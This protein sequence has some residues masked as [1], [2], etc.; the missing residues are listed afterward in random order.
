M[1]MQAERPEG[2]CA[3]RELRT[4]MSEQKNM[5]RDQIFEFDPENVSL[6]PGSAYETAQQ[7]ARHY[8]LELDPDRLLYPYRREAGVSQPLRNGSPVRGYPS[9]ESTGLDGHIGG[10]YLSG[11]AGFWAATHD[12]VFLDRTLIMLHGLAR[13]QKAHGTGFVGGMPHSARLFS[14]LRAGDIHAQSFDLDGSW[15]P[16]YNLHKVFAGLIETWVDYECEANQN[17]RAH[18]ASDLASHIVMR[19][20]EWWCDLSDHL[21]DAQF[22]QMLACEYGGL[23]ESFARLYEL[24]GNA[25]YLKQA[26]R[27]ELDP[28]FISL[29]RGKDCLTG[30][31]ANTQ[32]PKILGYARIAAITGE[33]PAIRAVSTFWNSVVHHRSVSIGAHSVAEHFNSPTDFSSMIL[34]R[35]GVETCNS[36][37]M[38]KLAEMLYMHT[39]AA[40]CLNFWERVTLNHL[41][42]SVSSEED[43]FVYFTPMRPRH[44]R[45]YSSAQ[46][47]FWCCVGTGL[48]SHSRYGRL[49]YTHQHEQLDVNIFTPS[50]LDWQQKMLTVTQNYR[51]LTSTENVGQLTLTATNGVKHTLVLAIRHPDWVLHADYAFHGCTAH[52]LTASKATP[53]QAKMVQ[54]EE[55]SYPVHF[56]RFALTWT[57]TCTISFHHVVAVTMETLPD[58]SQWVSLLRGNR[59]MALRGDEGDLRGLKADDSRTAHIASGSLRPFADLPILEGNV[60]D[61]VVPHNRSD[62]SIDVAASLP[63]RHETFRLVPFSTISASRYTIY[64]PHSQRGSAREMRK[65]LENIDKKEASR[66]RRICDS[67]HCG[68]QQSELDHHYNGTNDQQGHQEG[69]QFRF[70]KPGGHFSYKLTDWE[71]IG[72]TIEIDYLPTSATTNSTKSAIHVPQGA[73]S[74]TVGTTTLTPVAH[75][76]QDGLCADF[77]RLKRG[78]LAVDETMASRVTVSSVKRNGAAISTPRIVS[79]ALLR[80]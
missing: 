2:P 30:L 25:R 63:H 39:G 37:N 43:G 26:R 45:V 14:R 55:N 29:S 57:G 70:A 64:F 54:N 8:L 42:S 35:Q 60:A 72:E 68:E 21:T 80:G 73:Y 40:D 47:S 78:A 50:R 34:S 62:G 19:L 51:P 11:L 59:V 17:P 1:R 28:I 20:A 36:Y 69:T 33:K 38:S 23:N 18:E 75:S 6:L 10:H 24:T 5:V 65:H 71:R 61:I 7:A 79:I 74:L 77:Y 31:H 15:V 12:D 9:W 58:R 53:V 48:E 27:F 44:Y 56:D 4:V 13:C 52:A 22:T 41:V 49:I 46:Q 3:K 67:I 76:T 32:I 16:L 66:E